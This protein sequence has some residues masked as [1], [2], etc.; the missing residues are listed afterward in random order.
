MHINYVNTVPSQ[1][2]QDLITTSKNIIENII[3][4]SPGLRLEA[5]SLDYDMIVDVD[6]Q[7]LGAGILASARPTIANVSVSPGVP[8][9]QSVTLNS[10]RLNSTSLLSTTQFNGT[11]TVKIIPV[12]VHEM[13]HGLGIASINTPYYQIGWDQFLDSTKTWYVGPNGD[14]TQSAAIQ[15]YQEV[16]GQQVHRIPVENSFGTGTAYSHWEEGMKDGFVKDARYYDYGSGNVFHPALPDEIM[17]GVA[18]SRFFLTKL[19]VG[20]LQDHG[21]TV[22]MSSSYIAPYPAW[23]VEQP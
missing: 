5:V 19:T 17:T 4:K 21:Y 18:G 12:M 16:V 3:A 1:E 10:D 22:N 2:V 9:R 8:L 15:A 23:D 20:A 13:L 7:P 11:A 14:G 6:V